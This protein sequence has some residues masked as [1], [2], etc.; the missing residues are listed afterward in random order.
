MD[1]KNA[2]LVTIPVLCL[3]LVGPSVVAQN[4]ETTESDRGFSHVNGAA[5]GTHVDFQYDEGTGTICHW[6]IHGRAVIEEIAWDDFVA[7]VR[8]DGAS[9]IARDGAPPAADD[10]ATP[11]DAPNA[12]A[13]NTATNATTGP[14]QNV[15]VPPNGTT[16]GN[17]TNTT[18][19][20][21][22]AAPECPL[23]SD[24]DPNATAPGVESS[25]ESNA[26]PAGAPS[27]AKL[28]D[29]ASGLITLELRGGAHVRWD[30]D[31]NLT[32]EQEDDWTV[33]V[34]GDGFEA[35]LWTDHGRQND[36]F[37]VVGDAAEIASRHHANVMWRVIESDAPDGFDDPVLE[38]AIARAIVEG[39]VTTQVD[40]AGRDAVVG[41]F[42]NASAAAT[43]VQEDR[44][45]VFVSIGQTVLPPSGAGG[46]ARPSLPPTNASATTTDANMTTAT[47]STGATDAKATDPPASDGA[48]DALP[49]DALQPVALVLIEIS[50]DPFQGQRIV[51]LL[52]D[53]EL[54]AP[55]SVE[56]ATRIDRGEA[57]EALLLEDEDGNVLV[58]AS[59]PSGAHKLS[60]LAQPAVAE[61]SDA[62]PGASAIVAL[63]LVA[64]AAVV[65]RRGR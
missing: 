4:E 19:P 9:F 21:A 25:N 17:G 42:S 30:F 45:D 54:A 44:V 59:V 37:T 49:D 43:I 23:A 50:Q 24:G 13:T 26:R 7:A 38:D 62:I 39:L 34:R 41:D 8:V 29:V 52:D 20:P 33:W 35:V 56:D 28:H 55:G 11:T 14:P 64:A 27:T 6:S 46:E 3:A 31:D 10:D 5:N 65:R 40:V 48:D 47:S 1:L 15:T 60:V 22:P 57:S 32:L 16:T 2:S 58:L 51:V 18:A 36:G 12:T 53:T 61:G 63:T